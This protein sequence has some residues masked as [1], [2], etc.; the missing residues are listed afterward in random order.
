MYRHVG[1]IFKV[2]KVML[3]VV[4]QIGSFDDDTQCK[5]CFFD[6]DDICCK[7]E[8]IENKKA[9][10][11]SDDQRGDSCNV[12]FV[13]TE[14]I[15]TTTFLPLETTEPMFTKRETLAF[16]FAKAFISCPAP[17][18]VDGDPH[19]FIAQIFDLAD[20]FIKQS[21]EAE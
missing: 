14:E 10:D 12:I 16:G 17:S 7:H 11:C 13:P 6:K 18:V 2:G 1:E 19:T 5:G 8:S 3:K 20:E 21:E 15:G 9:G 4:P